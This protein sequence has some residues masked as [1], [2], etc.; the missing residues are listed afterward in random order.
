MPL[1]PCCHAGIG[2][3]KLGGAPIGAEDWPPPDGGIKNSS[4]C[5]PPKKSGWTKLSP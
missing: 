4:G 5:C 1:E 3:E 2:G